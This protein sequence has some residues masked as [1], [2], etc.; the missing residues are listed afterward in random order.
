MKKIKVKVLAAATAIMMMAFAGSVSVASINTSE[1]GTF[2]YNLTKSGTS[3]TAATSITKTSSSTKVIT[4]L[5]V[6]NNN[7]TGAV[8]VNLQKTVTGGKSSSIR[9]NN[10]TA[11]TLAAFSTHEARGKNSV[12]RYLAKT[13]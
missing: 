7:A 5:E 1:F 13:F 4:K 9:A 2:T 12:A 10:L 11:S 8:L 3:V 6:Q